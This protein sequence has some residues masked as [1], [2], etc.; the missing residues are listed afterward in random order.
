MQLAIPSAHKEPNPHL[1]KAIIS[2]WLDAHPDDQFSSEDLDVSLLLHSMFPSHLTDSVD[3]DWAG[4]WDGFLPGE[5]EA[6]K[7]EQIII[8]VVD[9][10]ITLDDDLLDRLAD[11]VLE[12]LRGRSE[13]IETPDP[14]WSTQSA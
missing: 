13:S 10:S 12:R 4:F 5:I 14:T 6:P 2:D 8:E 7:R 11:L 3:L 9:G 1:F